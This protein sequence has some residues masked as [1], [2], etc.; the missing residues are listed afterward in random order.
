MR[1]YKCP[2]CGKEISE[3]TALYQHI[4]DECLEKYGSI[5]ENPEESE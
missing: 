3:K 5:G 4:C 1:E 2:S